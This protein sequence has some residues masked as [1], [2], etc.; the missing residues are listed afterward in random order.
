MRNEEKIIVKVRLQEPGAVASKVATYEVPYQKNMRIIDALNWLNAAGESIAYR[1]FCSSKKCGACAM[2]VNGV[3]RL[4]CW[5]ALEKENLI[6]PLDNFEVLRDLVVNRE[7]YQARYI[8]LKPHVERTHTPPFPEPLKHRDI[9][10]TYK[11]MD[12]IE[13]GICTSGCPAYTGVDGPFPGPWALVQAAKFARDPRDELDRSVE[14]ENSGADFCMSCYRCEELCPVEVPIVSEAIEPLRGM[15]ARGPTG[16]AS[17][18]IA[19]AENIRKNAY[20]Y[21]PSLFLRVRGVFGAI[22]SIGML[23]GMFRHGKTKL[24][25]RASEAARSAIRALFRAADKQ[26]VS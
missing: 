20:V 1:W 19:F 18:P 9:L 6:E 2:K 7:A 3:P 25:G 21:S 5:E 17:F 23:A 4:T 16:K 12:C 14:L 26:G 8:S 10:G 15:A 11:L 24:F 22:G 13:C